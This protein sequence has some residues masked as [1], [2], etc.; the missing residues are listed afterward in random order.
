MNGTR[1]VVEAVGKGVELLLTM[2]RKVCTLG[3]VL[4]DY[5]IGVLAISLPNQHRLQIILYKPA[6]QQAPLQRLF[7]GH[8]LQPDQMPELSLRDLHHEALQPRSV[9]LLD[10]AGQRRA[11]FRLELLTS[12]GGLF[13]I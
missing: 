2:L 6:G 13:C 4:A 3:H 1:E 11:V 12:L 10:Q 8:R 7:T 5:P 9:L